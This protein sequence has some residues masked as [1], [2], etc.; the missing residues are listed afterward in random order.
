MKKKII[1]IF[2]CTLLVV[3]ALSATGVTNVQTTQNMKEN[4]DFE[5]YLRTSDNSLGIITIKIDAE[6]VWVDDDYNL[7]GGAIKTGDKITGKYIYDS[8]LADSNPDPNI[9]EYIYTSSSFGFEVKAGGFVFKTNPSNVYFGFEIS[10]NYDATYY[11]LDRCD[12]FSVYNMPLSNGLVVN[13]FIFRLNDFTQTALS[14][15]AL[16]TTAPVLSDWQEHFLWING[17]SPSDPL[18]Q[19]VVTANVTKATKS[20][21]RDVYFT[22]Q[23]ILNW[24]FEHFANIFPLLRQLMKLNI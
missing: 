19:Y 24:L 9:G 13:S 3:T 10:N 11:Q 15:D 2:I 5:P 7:L 4:S 22:S 1:G 6:V 14:N 16:P 17:W 20:R 8:G 23:P 12:V 18:K 21:A